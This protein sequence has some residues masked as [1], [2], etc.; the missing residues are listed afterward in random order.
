MRTEIKI[1]G[2]GGQGVVTLSMLIVSAVNLHT[3]KNAVQTDAYGPQ[4]R[5]GDCWAE[6]VIDDSEIDY[7]RILLSDYSILLSPVAFASYV[8]DIKSTGTIIVDPTTVVI[9]S[10][11]KSNAE[12]FE[13][14]AQDIAL[15]DF[16]TAIVANIIL[17][18]AFIVM[19]KIIPVHAAREAVRN[20]VPPKAIEL[21]MKAFDR[22]INVG[23]DFIAK[24]NKVLR[25]VA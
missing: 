22:G 15:E 3:K 11:F 19:T 14:P 5:G 1:A 12:L 17:F 13:L 25:K 9:P 7:P 10:E 24:Q 21:N 18:S 8:N 20:T 6:V 2:S 16:G 4:A 23:Q